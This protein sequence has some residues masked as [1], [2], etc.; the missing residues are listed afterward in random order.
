[1]IRH[2]RKYY[3]TRPKKMS[4][5]EELSFRADSGKVNIVSGIPNQTL[6]HSS[7]FIKCVL[8]KMSSKEELSFRA[9]SGKV[10][11]VSVIPNS[12]SS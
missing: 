8:K 11:I 7:N 10:N 1:M 5:K 2:I 9:D 6:A 3:V 12:K 4:S